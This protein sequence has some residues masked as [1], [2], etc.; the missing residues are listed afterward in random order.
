[1]FGGLLFD[2][3]FG[4]IRWG[5]RITHH[6]IRKKMVRNLKNGDILPKFELCKLKS[7]KFEKFMVRKS[8]KQACVANFS[9]TIGCGEASGVKGRQTG[10]EA[11]RK[12][13]KLEV[14]QIG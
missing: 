2:R 7:P 12:R 1:M 11:S 3:K 9:A 4:K 13:S 6:N 5:F 14:N 8:K 10:R